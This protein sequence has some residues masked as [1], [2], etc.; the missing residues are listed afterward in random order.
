MRRAVLRRDRSDDHG[1]RGVLVADGLEPL[2]VMEPPWRDNRRCISCI[3]PGVYRVVPYRSPRFR[4]CLH[5]L[6]V[7]G[8]SHIL[9]HRGNVGGDRAKGLHTHT[10][11]CLL[12]GIR[13]ARIRVKGRV[14]DAVVNSTT[15]FRHLMAWAGGAPFELEIVHA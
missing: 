10:L 15:G 14:Q 11:G 5:V 12:P 7:P 9:I 4:D 2:H 8:R 13:R 1:T 3:P 6:D